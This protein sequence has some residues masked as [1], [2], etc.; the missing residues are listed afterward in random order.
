M[1]EYCEMSK[2]KEKIIM[3]NEGCYAIYDENSKNGDIL[4]V[5][6]EHTSNYFEMSYRVNEE[7]FQLSRNCKKLLDKRVSPDGYIVSQRV[8]ECVGQREDEHAMMIITP[9]YSGDLSY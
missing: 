6:K 9:R 4:V 8:G 2:N 7:M 3:E 1:C 5:T